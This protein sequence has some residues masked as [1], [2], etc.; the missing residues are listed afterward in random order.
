[1]VYFLSITA[2]DGH[3]SKEIF[4]V[5]YPWIPMEIFGPWGNCKV[6]NFVKSVIGFCFSLI[7]A[8]FMNVIMPVNKYS[9]DEIQLICLFEQIFFLFPVAKLSTATLHFAACH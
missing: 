5:I 4:L 1:M 9:I 8:P 6:S 7:V 3:Q 2:G